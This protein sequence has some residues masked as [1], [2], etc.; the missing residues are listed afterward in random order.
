MQQAELQLRIIEL[1]NYG[2][3]AIRLNALRLIL[4]VEPDELQIALAELGDTHRYDPCRLVRLDDLLE[5][6]ADSSLSRPGTK[7]EGDQ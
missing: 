2:Y 4:E 7:S 6:S 3:L 5:G 1:R